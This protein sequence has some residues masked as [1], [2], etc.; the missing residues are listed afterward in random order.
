MCYISVEVVYGRGKMPFIDET[1]DQCHKLPKGEVEQHRAPR[2]KKKSVER[3]AYTQKAPNHRYAQKTDDDKRNAPLTVSTSVEHEAL[4]AQYR[5]FLDKNKS[6][7]EKVQSS[8]DKMEKKEK[9]A[10]AP[11]V[12]KEEKKRGR[13][14]VGRPPMSSKA[15]ALIDRQ[16]R[17][18]KREARRKEILTGS[19]RKFYSPVLDERWEGELM[20]APRIMRTNTNTT[21]SSSSASDL[22]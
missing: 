11:A 1:Q 4:M 7:L 10:D 18:E 15:K 21:L 16:E 20:D 22:H 13:L 17:R 5:A 2:N 8:Q 6:I 12:K 14:G 9:V 19:N 3:G